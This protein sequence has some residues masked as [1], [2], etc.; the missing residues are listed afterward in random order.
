MFK[1]VEMG[2]LW[3]GN[4]SLVRVGSS[5]AVHWELS[6][7]VGKELFWSSVGADSCAVCMLLVVDIE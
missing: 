3:K 7:F 6:K 2:K 4:L 1:I 5:R